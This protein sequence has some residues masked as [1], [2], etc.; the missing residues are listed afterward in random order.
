MAQAYDPEAVE[1]AWCAWWEKQKYFTPDAK[2]AMSTKPENKFIMVIPPPNVTGSLHLGH[3]ITTAI[4]DCLT[5]WHRQC[6]KVALW[7]P[8]TDHAGTTHECRCIIM[9]FRFRSPGS[10]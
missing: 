5:R 8:G 9:M 4:E 6:G 1:S 10:L 2:A 3:A 7:V